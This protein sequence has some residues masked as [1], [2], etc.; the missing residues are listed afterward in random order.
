[1]KVPVRCVGLSEPLLSGARFNH[2]TESRASSAPAAK[3]LD[4][5]ASLV[6]ELMGGLPTIAR[7]QEGL[8]DHNADRAPVWNVPTGRKNRSRADDPHGDDGAARPGG[9]DERP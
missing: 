6:C 1:V 2:E 9:N 5:L 3:G 4:R 7:G 8:P